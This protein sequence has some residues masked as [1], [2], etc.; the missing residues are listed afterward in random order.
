MGNEPKVSCGIQS[1]VVSGQ[2]NSES[3]QMPYS[4]IRSCLYDLVIPTFQLCGHVRTKS[5]SNAAEDVAKMS[6]VDFNCQPYPKSLDKTFTSNTTTTIFYTD[7]E[8][9]LPSYEL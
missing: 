1:L 4:Y 9:L 6:G 7:C 3:S 5:A 2:D 8:Q